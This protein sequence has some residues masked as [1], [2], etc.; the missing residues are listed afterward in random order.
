[1]KFLSA[2]NGPQLFE[3]LLKINFL[4]SLFDFPQAVIVEQC[5]NFRYDTKTVQP[6]Y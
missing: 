1:M 5:C 6:Q 4:Y 3:A 2:S